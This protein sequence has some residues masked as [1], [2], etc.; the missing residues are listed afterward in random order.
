MSKILAAL[1]SMRQYQIEL[2]GK[3]S[4]QAK[5]SSYIS[6][7]TASEIYL[8][9]F[10]IVLKNS[11]PWCFMSSYPK[12]NGKHVDAQPTYFQTVL[13]EEWGYNGLLMSD[14]G[15]VSNA[16]E[17]VKYGY[18]KLDEAGWDELMC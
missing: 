7:T 6:D 10:G 17:S 16:I 8:R 13:R 15:A 11:D 3:R 5:L 1:Q 2:S 14:W 4:A 18:V 12:V 9:A